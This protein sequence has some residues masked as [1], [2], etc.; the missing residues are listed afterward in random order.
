ML[1]YIDFLS[2]L[3]ALF[4]M[5]QPIKACAENKCSHNLGKGNIQPQ[6][7]SLCKILVRVRLYSF[8]DI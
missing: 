2:I 5:K 6:G 4:Q 1:H 7:K 8:A 3:S